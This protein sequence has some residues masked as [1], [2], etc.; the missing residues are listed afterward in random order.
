MRRSDSLRFTLRELENR[1][2][3]R[4]VEFAPRRWFS[5][6]LYAENDEPQPQVDV[7]VGFLMT[8]CAPSR[9]SL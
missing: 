7:A 9:S 5:S 6:F 4:R 2:G 8:N 3:R 1:S